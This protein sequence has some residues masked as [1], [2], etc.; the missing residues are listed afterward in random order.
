MLRWIDTVVKN[1]VA[2]PLCCHCQAEG[3][4]LCSNCYEQLDFIVTDPAAT[5]DQS[6]NL[7][8]QTTHLGS[9]NGVLKSLI[10]KL[11]YQE[12]IEVAQTLAQLLFHTTCIPPADLLIPI[13]AHPVR[14]K[15]R[16]FNQALLICQELSKLTQVETLPCLRRVKTVAPQ[17]QVK[18][19]QL[20]QERQH[21]TMAADNSLVVRER[22]N[23]AH[24]ILVIDDVYTT[25]ATMHEAARALKCV[26]PQLQVSGLTL[27]HA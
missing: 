26:N 13:P 24:H 7:L 22:L 25:G 2:P 18:D 23:A 5:R 10:V 15:E 19:K 1:L 6:T 20:R 11:K 27:A 8:S 4:F 17:A 21:L 12:Q 14:L 16:G 9:F 3:S